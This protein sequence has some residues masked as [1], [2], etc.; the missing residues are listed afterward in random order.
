MRFL[1][2]VVLLLTVSLSAA[3]PLCSG[4]DTP[5]ETAS[6]NELQAA[7]LVEQMAAGEFD[8]ATAGF[9]ET[10][11][12]V[13]PA[14]K[15]QEAW[16]AS[17]GKLGKFSKVASTKSGKVKR[18][19]QELDV[20]VVA[21]EFESQVVEARVVFGAEGRISGL[22]FSAPRQAFAGEEDLYTGTLKAGVVQLR[23]AFHI[24]KSKS[25]A[26]AA[27]MD[28][29]DQGQNGLP[30]DSAKITEEKILLKAK[31]LGIEFEGTFS[32]DHETLE[33]EFRQAGQKF[34]LSMKK[35]DRV[36]QLKR[37]QMPKPPF[38]YS[39]VE[40]EYRNDAAKIRLA[41]TLTLPGSPG[42]HPAVILI[43]GSGAQDRD[44]TLAG[45]KP[46]WVIADALTRR[47]IAVLRVDDRGVGGSTGSV[48]E[49][50]SED[51]AG[52]VLAGVAFLKTRP[53]IDA[54]Q[55]GLIG[56]S[57]GGLVAPLAASKSPDV[58][59]IVLLA[60][61]AF[62]GTEILFQQGRALLLAG[63]ADEAA[64]EAQRD[65]Q[66]R[67]FE[68]LDQTADVEQARRLVIAAVA[69]QVVQK[70]PD[71]PDREALAQ[72]A[73]ESQARQLLS[74][75]FRGFLKFDPRP[76]LAK[77]KCPVL[78]LNGEKD[79]QVLPKE[80]LQGIREALELGKNPDFEI[81]EFPGLNHLFQTSTT[82]LPSEYGQIEETM[83]PVV[84]QTIGDWI[85][86]RAGK[87]P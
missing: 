67:L 57:E 71:G 86:V 28:S 4:A 81:I 32:K 51:F 59:F 65:L 22:F 77:V 33:G 35:V 46:F 45:H 24:G 1:S 18:A 66:S 61:T 7:K 60:G 36:P 83:A 19:G 69:E 20:A 78:A 14:E 76:V 42:P 63:G 40:V 12:K 85:L 34:P 56:H 79:L 70:L 64:L 44:E 53:E 58:A 87:S 50:T 49:S 9:D 82:G 73:G 15:L 10:M 38:P 17:T 47:G 2:R 80:N 27:T 8:S 25:G 52:D 6:P 30:F 26:D 39:A 16:N 21:C 54:R 75:W 84:L 5:A 31:T 62:P 55:I 41:G 13:L 43:T 68:I 23:L 37:P 48:S 72:T 11:L 74:P 29:L 3:V